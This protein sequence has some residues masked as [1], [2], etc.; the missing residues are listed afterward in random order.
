MYLARMPMRA[1]YDSSAALESA[2]IRLVLSVS[3]ENRSC[4]EGATASDGPSSQS[5]DSFNISVVGVG[6][7]LMPRYPDPH[8]TFHFQG[9]GIGGVEGRGVGEYTTYLKNNG[10][11]HERILSLP[12]SPSPHPPP[13]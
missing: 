8:L 6:I 2:S 1:M 12:N 13:P 5:Q 4:G 9:R 7:I 10:I 3:S 11:V